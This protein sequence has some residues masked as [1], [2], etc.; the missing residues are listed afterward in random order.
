MGLAVDQQR[1]DR[2]AH[3]VDR[4]VADD[5]DRAGLGVHLDLAD[6]AAA[7]EG[8]L[9]VVDLGGGGERAAGGGVE[10]PDRPVGADDRETALGIGDVGQS[11]FQDLGRGR[12]ALLDDLLGRPAHDDR[13]EA[14]RPAG[15]GAAADADDVGVAGDQVHRL[16]RRLEQRGDHLGEGRFVALAG[17]LGPDHHVDPAL[18]ADRHLGALMRRAGGEVE[19]VGDA[20]AA[21]PPA[22]A[23][24]GLAGGGAPPVAERGGGLHRG[25]EI[26]AVIDQPEPVLERDRRGR[27]DVAAPDLQPVEAEPGGGDV[28]QPLHRVGDLGPPGRPVGVGRRRVRRDRA[29]ARVAGA[30]PVGEREDLHAL[31]EGHEGHRVR[32]DVAGVE[33]AQGQEAAVGGERELG[34]DREVARLVIGQEHLGAVAGPFHRPAEP[35]RRPQH[36]GEFGVERVARAVAAAD[37][38]GGDPDV[39][40][41]D[42][43]QRRQILLAAHGAA[44]PGMERVPAG[45]RVEGADRRARLHRHPGA[46]RQRGLQDDDLMRLG[47]GAGHGPGVAHRAVDADV[48][49]ALGPQS[50]QVGG[51]A[52]VDH[53]LEGPVGDGHA[54]GPVAGR[55]GG[56]AEHHGDR[57]ADMEDPVGRQRLMRR[58]EN[59]R[60]VGVGDR[61]VRRARREN[62]VGQR[63]EP[64]GG[65]VAAGQHRGHAGQGRRAAGLDSL[66]RGMG[67]GAADQRRMGLARHVDVVAEPAVAGDQTEVLAAPDRPADHSRK[68]STGRPRTARPCSD[69]L[70]SQDTPICPAPARTSRKKRCSLLDR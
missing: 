2:P 36:D 50:R 11:G 63:P 1:V 58:R 56:L 53:R 7:P 26:A 70:A 38:G 24:F 40:L 65:G 16:E 57:L 34:A 51:P 33:D 10:Q 28:D 6:V 54:L 60:A 23:G 66:D 52:G 43:E 19:I 8:G 25:R 30:D 61:H 59:R 21:Q 48:G 13:A 12:P 20:D 37:V 64:V 55:G 46:A 14:H 41:G 4:A 32:A 17:I 39:V 27:D 69:P 18:G 67:V 42:A 35:A 5:L 68:L 22:R 45:G 31:D 29:G 47:E 62:G 49:A 44:G 3:V 15:I 9:A